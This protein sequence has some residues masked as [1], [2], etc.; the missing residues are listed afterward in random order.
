M[1]INRFNE[2]ISAFDVVSYL[3]IGYSLAKLLSEFLNKISKAATEMRVNQ[4]L[5]KS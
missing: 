4:L 1:H 5:T 3:V 2:N